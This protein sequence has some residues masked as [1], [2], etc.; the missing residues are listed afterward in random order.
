MFR[1]LMSLKNKTRLVGKVTS[2]RRI[3]PTVKVSAKPA[4][5][6]DAG[7]SIE[8]RKTE[9]LPEDFNKTLACSSVLDYMHRLFKPNDKQ[10]PIRVILDTYKQKKLNPAIVHD[11]NEIVETARKIMDASKNEA[12]MIH[13]IQEVIKGHREYINVLYQKIKNNQ[14]DLTILSNGAHTP[15]SFYLSVEHSLINLRENDKNTFDEFIKKAQ[16]PEYK[17]QDSVAELYLKEL[18]FIDSDGVMSEQIRG[19]ALMTVDKFKPG[20]N[21]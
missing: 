14:N 9:L 8:Q 7:K 6:L 3:F 4:K 10:D 16:D 13:D 12:Y 19:I 11:R 5:E 1:L 15:T 2:K 21:I 20:M 18:H 17:I